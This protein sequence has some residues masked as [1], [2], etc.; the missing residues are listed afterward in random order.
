MFRFFKYIIIFLAGYKL[1]KMLFAQTQQQRVEPRPPRQNINNNN[2]P[3]NQQTA[4]Q[5]KF[6]DAEFIDYEEVK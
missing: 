2:Q 4:P 6:K 5:T 1:L 3:Q